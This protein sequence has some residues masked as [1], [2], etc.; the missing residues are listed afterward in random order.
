M[1][2]CQGELAATAVNAPMVPAEVLRELQ[3]FVSLAEGLGRAAV[4]LVNTGGF[5]DV[6]ITY[7]TPRGDDL[8]TRLLRAMVIKGILEQITTSTV[9]LVNADVLARARGLRIIESTLPAA[10]KVGGCTCLPAGC[11]HEQAFAQQPMKGLAD[12]RWFCCCGS[13]TDE[14][15]QRKGPVLVRKIAFL[16]APA[17]HIP[18]YPALH[19]LVQ[20]YHEYSACGPC[21]QPQSQATATALT[22]TLV[23]LRKYSRPS[24]WPW[25][26]T[27]PSSPPPSAVAP[28]RSQSQGQSR[29]LR[30]TLC[31]SAP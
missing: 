14:Q 31:A 13:A 8:D 4:Q 25:E 10:G 17:P 19:A 9:N 12:V 27:T 21:S 18:C 22:V 28:A 6:H 2:S 20:A 7:A 30:P 26:P 23:G 11:C 16:R 29:A 15:L 1:S 24:E 3:P 5:T